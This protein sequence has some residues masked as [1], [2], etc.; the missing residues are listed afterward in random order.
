MKISEFQYSILCLQKSQQG[1][2]TLDFAKV[3]SQLFGLLMI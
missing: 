3:S 2:D 1:I